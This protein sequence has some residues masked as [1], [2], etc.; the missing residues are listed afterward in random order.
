MIAQSQH[1]SLGVSL[2]VAAGVTFFLHYSI[3]PSI[4]EMYRELQIEIPPLTKA[5]ATLSQIVSGILAIVGI[6]FMTLTPNISELEQKL[7]NYQDHDLVDITAIPFKNYEPV[8]LLVLGAFVGL[9][10][11]TVIQPIY[12]LT[13]AF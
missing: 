13:S 9:L 7:I 1:L 6:Y 5:V 8:F 12:S 4:F 3:I 11:L 2:I 10:V